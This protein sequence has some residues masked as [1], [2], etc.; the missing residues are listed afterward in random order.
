MYRVL[1]ADDEKIGRHGVQFLLKQMDVDFDIVE[2]KHGKEALE[3]ISNQSFDMLLTDIKM[4]F[5]DG[6]QLIKEAIK[7]QPHLKIA[8]FSGYS[9][10]EYAKEALSLGVMEYIL[11]PVN[12][13]E[14]KT[15]IDK[16]IKQVDD[17]KEKVVEE[18]NNYEIIKEHILFNLVSGNSDNQI[19]KKLKNKDISFK[20]YKRMMLIEFADNFFED[21]DIILNDLKATIHIAFDYLNLNLQQSLL[22]FEEKNYDRLKTISKE[23]YYMIQVKYNQKCYIGV[24]KE[25]TTNQE[26]KDKADILE[27]L[28]ENRYFHPDTHFFSEE[29]SLEVTLQSSQDIEELT[30]KVKQSIKMKDIEGIKKHFND[31]YSFYNSQNEFSNDYVK[32][33]FSGMIKDVYQALSGI[34]EKKLDQLIVRF[35]RA[36]DYTSIVNV[37]NEF[38][39]LLEEEFKRTDTLTHKEIETVI[40]YIYQNYSLD[41]GIDLLAD[42]VC[43]APSYLSYI[44]KKET[45]ENLSKFIKRVR[46]EK[47]KEMLENTHEKIVS[48]SVAV[49]YQNVSYFCQSFREYYGIS[50]QK[51]RNQG[52]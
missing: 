23:I 17:I 40:R 48:I 29:D 21:A 33:M 4:P 43:L 15:I 18:Y 45:Q 20:E 46:M 3:Y 52:D 9:D 51:Y 37:M 6:I 10:F 28:L 5:L 14:F 24:S 27:N 2:A 1:V 32:F 7:L 47:A 16:I 13:E 44:F 11:K 8:I 19:E 31:F 12:P 34:D 22:F 50:P 39:V 49:G 30:K 41:L 25:L 42:L 35:Y 36:S 38:I 26:I